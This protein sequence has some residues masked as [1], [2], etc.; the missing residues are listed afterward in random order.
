V[1]FARKNLFKRAH[2]QFSRA[3]FLVDG[4]FPRPLA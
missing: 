1:D 4:V 2:H 3:V